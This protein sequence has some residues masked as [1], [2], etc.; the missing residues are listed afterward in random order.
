VGI[1]E[2]SQALAIETD[3]G[4]ELQFTDRTKSANGGITIERPGMER[5]PPSK[6]NGSP[7]LIT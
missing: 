1:K 3:A 4:L 6:Y 5:C 2:D 7:F